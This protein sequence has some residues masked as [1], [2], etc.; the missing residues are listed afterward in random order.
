MKNKLVLLTLVCILLVNV[1]SAQVGINKTLSYPSILDIQKNNNG[2]YYINSIRQLLNL[3][4]SIKKTNRNFYFQIL[5]IQY[6][7]V[8][9]FK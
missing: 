6:S 3:D 8:G 2:S 1:S 4:D 5:C 9:A 7:L